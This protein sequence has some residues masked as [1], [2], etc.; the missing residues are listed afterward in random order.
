MTIT[1][2]L[3]PEEEQRLQ[4]LAAQ[5]GKDV[6]EIA[7]QA[8]KLLLPRPKPTPEEIAAAKAELFSTRPALAMQR[9]WTTHK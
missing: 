2:E 4:Q 6:Q 8:V 3:S 5:E 9:D 7:L 1:L